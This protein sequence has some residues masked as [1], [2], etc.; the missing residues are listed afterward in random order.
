MFSYIRKIFS[1]WKVVLSLHSHNHIV[2]IILGLYVYT[3]F[4]N[5]QV[6][7]F[8]WVALTGQ[9]G[10]GIRAC[11]RV[12][13]ALDSRSKGLEFSSHCWSCVEVFNKLLVP[14]SLSL[15][16]ID[17][18]LVVSESYIVMTGYFCSKVRKCWLIPRGYM[19]VEECV[20]VSGV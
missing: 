16:N 9:L 14:Y 19:T 3:G 20:H 10:R 11:G 5:T 2:I 7:Q 15:P 18:Y 6:A 8:I 17:R 12:D 1:L 13:K 4:L